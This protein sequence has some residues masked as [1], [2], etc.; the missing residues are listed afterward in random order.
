MRS[1]KRGSLGAAINSLTRYRRTMARSLDAIGAK[2]PSGLGPMLEG[3]ADAATQQGSTRLT[4]TASFGANPGQLRMLSYVPRQLAPG[5]PLV[6]VLHGCQ[7]TAAGFDHAS[8]WSMLAERHGFAVLYPEQ[9]RAN[10]AMLCFGW[11]DA[12]KVA[13][14]RGEV[15]SV[16]Q[17]VG[18]MV[19]R[20]RL[21][22]RRVFATGLSAGGA[23]AAALLACHPEVFAAGAV[24]AG[25]PFGVARNTAEALDCMAHGP[26]LPPANLAERVRAVTPGAARW[27]LLSIWHGDADRTVVPANATALAGQ[28]AVLHDAREAEAPRDVGVRRQLWRN[29]AGLVAVE[30][31]WLPGMAHG[32]P[33]DAAGGF[34]HAAPFMLDVGLSA[35]A[36]IAAGWGIAG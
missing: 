8:A 3:L 20:H 35:P 34:G 11:F 16:R 23:M 12:A 4:E 26:N 36:K 22:P 13:P 24:V 21:D 28:W 25:L 32:L 29:G 7:Q 33:I 31:I 6:V 18:T 9:R 5:A 27:P 17:M 10:N 2:L 19:E 30:Q 14:G 15:G 1:V